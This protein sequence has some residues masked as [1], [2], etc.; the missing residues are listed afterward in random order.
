MRRGFPNVLRIWPRLHH[1]RSGSPYPAVTSPGRLS[2]EFRKP[3]FPNRGRYEGDDEGDQR[4][5][6][7]VEK[8]VLSHVLAVKRAVRNRS[9]IRALSN[10]VLAED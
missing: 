9:S 4:M 1:K 10:N 3:V 7:P 2:K 6:K 5:K 8:S